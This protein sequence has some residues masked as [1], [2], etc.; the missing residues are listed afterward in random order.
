M[1]NWT[2]PQEKSIVL[3]RLQSITWLPIGLVRKCNQTGLFSYYQNW[4]QLTQVIFDVTWSLQKLIWLKCLVWNWKK[5][6]WNVERLINLEFDYVWLPQPIQQL[7]FNLTWFPDRIAQSQ[8]PN[9][10]EHYISSLDWTWTNVISTNH[11]SYLWGLLNYFPISFIDFYSCD[12][13]L[14]SDI[15]KN[16]A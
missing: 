7:E 11:I 8:R 15:R 2:K 5:P 4:G 14:S 10:Y 13:V 12:I 1:V 6:V 3:N 16:E 9:V